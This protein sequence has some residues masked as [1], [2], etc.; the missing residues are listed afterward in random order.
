MC[1]APKDIELPYVYSNAYC[2]FLTVV[3][4]WYTC[5]H[6]IT[7]NED[8]IIRVLMLLSQLPPVDITKGPCENQQ[9]IPADLTC[10]PPYKLSKG[11]CIKRSAKLGFIGCNPVRCIEIHTTSYTR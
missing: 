10:D 6:D 3:F 7:Y 1:Y 11:I 5:L 2:I 8:V 4:T 9:H